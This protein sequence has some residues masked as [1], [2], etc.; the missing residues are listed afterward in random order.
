MSRF[1][2][3]FRI[4]WTVAC[5]WLPRYLAAWLL[6]LVVTGM[7][8]ERGWNW[9]AFPRRDDG[10]N[11][12]ATIDFGGQ[13]VCGKLLLRGEGRFL[14]ERHHQ[15]IV[16]QEFYPPDSH[17]FLSMRVDGFRLEDWSKYPG[18]DPKAPEVL[19]SY[20]LPLGACDGLGAAAAVVGGYE[21]AQANRE[22][23]GNPWQKRDPENL[24][25]WLLGSDDDRAKETYASCVLPLAAP[26]GLSAAALVAVGKDHLWTR[27]KM[28]RA[29]ARDTGGNFYPPIH[30]FWYAPL[31]LLPPLTSYRM[32]MLVMVAFAFLAGLGLYKVS[33]GA[34]WWPVATLLLLIFPGVFSAQALGHSSIIILTLLIWGYYGLQQNDDVRGG[35]LW[36]FIAYKPTWAVIYFVSLVIARRW[37]AALA[38]GTCGV[39]QILLTIPFVGVHSW[40]EWFT[41]SSAATPL[42]NQYESW[43]NCS[44]DLNALPRRLLVDFSQPFGSR[45]RFELTVITCLLIATFFEATVRLTTLRMR[46]RWSP[47]GA[48]F[49]LTG[50][51]MC[52]WRI[53]YYDTLLVALPAALL[54][55][56]PTP[57][58]IPYFWRRS[59]LEWTFH[60]ATLT[61]PQRN[62][63]WVCNPLIVVLLP[64]L[65]MEP[66]W[67]NVPWVVPLFAIL[68]L[69]AGWLWLRIP[70]DVSA[71]AP[72]GE[73]ASVTPAPASVP[74]AATWTSDRQLIKPGRQLS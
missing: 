29:S 35:I 48:A 31:A 16:Y 9:F 68:W 74:L 33:R 14:Y 49:L 39:L 30:A 21:A 55:C 50:V 58:T 23:F 40:R 5:H 15:W 44:R 71:S 3:W 51:W 13:W 36:G 1:A 57:V 4:T 43:V 52:C 54:F 64:L 70:D 53:T 59:R 61:L 8:I 69:W 26:D 12:H 19:A 42:Y 38:M 46:G 65:V 27:R 66:G 34:L 67:E 10:T 11:G 73:A 72:P 37:K 22:K 32:T 62:F 7:L 28:N 45:D 56:T 6:L 41:I 24:M 18:N 47:A 17:A 63:G 20:L 60:G 25:S 2:R